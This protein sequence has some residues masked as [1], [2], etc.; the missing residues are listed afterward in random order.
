MVGFS[1]A[2][3][4]SSDRKNRRL[5]LLSGLRTKGSAPGKPENEMADPF[6]KNAIKIV[7]QSILK[8]LNPPNPDPV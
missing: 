2:I 6:L 1:P 8:S 3:R 7:V 4:Y 5:S